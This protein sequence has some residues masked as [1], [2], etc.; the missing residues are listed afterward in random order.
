MPL[1]VAYPAIF[2]PE[3]NGGYFIEFP[4]VDGAC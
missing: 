3:D 4:D 2:H 1:L